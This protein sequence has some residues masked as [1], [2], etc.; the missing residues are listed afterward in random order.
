M[1]NL[2]NFIQLYYL[3]ILLVAG[4]LT[5]LVVL[6]RRGNKKL[7]YR[8]ALMAVTQAERALGSGTGPIKL[9]TAISYVY[10]NLPA[11]IRLFF[12]QAEIENFIEDA[13]NELKEY[14]NSGATLDS[15]DTEK[16]R[17]DV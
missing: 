2:L 1:V 12:T 11:T 6:W 8:I 15:Y 5:A 13:V 10:R 14:L 3:D 17:E 4:A 9:A 7:V 16:L